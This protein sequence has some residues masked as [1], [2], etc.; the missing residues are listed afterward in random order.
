[1][2]KI[3]YD[4]L[5]FKLR[6]FIN[7]IWFLRH[8]KLKTLRFKL[9][10]K[11]VTKHMAKEHQYIHVFLKGDT[12]MN[13]THVLKKWCFKAGHCFIFS[14]FCQHVWE[15]FWNIISYSLSFEIS[16]CRF[17][18]SSHPEEVATLPQTIYWTLF[19]KNLVGGEERVF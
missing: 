3:N 7:I 19:E 11:W 15:I 17:W 14:Y 1:M 16:Y 6:M 10:R 13:C 5:I 2:L 9:K 4:E 12:R 8:T 18:A